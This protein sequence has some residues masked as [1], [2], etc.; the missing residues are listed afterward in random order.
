M[1]G[2]FGY[3]GKEVK[4]SCLIEGLKRLEYRGYDSCGVVSYNLEKFLCQKNSGKIQKL[5]KDLGAKLN[6]KYSSAL[7]HTRWATHGKPVKLNAHPHKSFKK[8]IYVVHNGIIENHLDLKKKLKKKGY[9]FKTDTDSEVVANLIASFYKNSIEKA[10]ASAVKKL[11]GAFAL[12]VLSES[13]PDKIVAVRHRSPLLI[14]VADKGFFLASDLPA[15]IPLAKEVIY[16]KEKQIA[17]LE[18]NKIKLYSFEGKK[19]RVK[20][21]KIEIKTEEAKKKGFKH[22][23]L[24]EI[25]EQPKVLQDSLDIYLKDS[26]INFDQLK[27]TKKYL[28]G[29]KN[30]FITACGTAFHAAYVAKYFLERHTKIKVEVDTSSEFRYR[31]FNV[32][33]GDLFIAIS[34]SGET[35]DTLAALKK[36]KQQK[37]KVLSICNVIGSSL[38]RESDSFIYTPAGPEIGVASTKAYT[39]QLIC[40]YLFCLHLATIKNTVPKEER[41]KILKELSK[42]PFYQRKILKQNKKIAAIAKKFSKMGCFLFLGRGINFP[43]ALEGALKLKEISYIPAEGYPAGEM[44]HGPIALI[45]EYRAVVCIAPKDHLYEKMASNLQEIK[46][47]KG[48]ILAIINPADKEILPF[49]DQAIYI[50]RLN[51]QELSPLLVAVALQLLAYSVARNLGAEIDQPRNLAKSVTVE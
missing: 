16:L 18:E 6:D 22:F 45:D 25:Y 1:C 43:S 5:K 4:L 13:E 38:V 33:K 47:R 46:A 42:I 14:G 3:K 15:V 31:D 41:K 39:T 40:L 26:K 17:V 19:L 7:L 35:A 36:A 37:A 50:P 2:I 51:Y 21:E 29:I 23:M 9:K 34:Q 44:K 49:A 30:I 24:K 12:G 27:L 48:K 10:V 8:N 20:K 11:K 32:S 28:K